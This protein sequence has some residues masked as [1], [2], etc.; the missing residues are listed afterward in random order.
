MKFKQDVQRG[1]EINE[2]AP[3][4][5]NSSEISQAS[6]LE[7]EKLDSFAAVFSNNGNQHSSHNP[8][9]DRN[10]YCYNMTHVT[11]YNLGQRLNC[12]DN[13]ESFSIGMVVALMFTVAAEILAHHLEHKFKDNII[14]LTMLNKIYKELMFMGL[15]GLFINMLESL[16]MFE[17]LFELSS[18]LATK[19]GFP[20]EH[21]IHETEH[22]RVERRV[23]IFDFVHVSLFFLSVFYVSMV[24]LWYYLMRRTWK[25]WK[26]YEE[27]SEDRAIS[28]YKHVRDKV[29]SSN[30]IALM[31]KYR[32][33]YNYTC[34]LDRLNYFTVRQRFIQVN[35]LM[36][37]SFRFDHYLKQCALHMFVHIIEIDSKTWIGCCVVFGINYLRNKLFDFSTTNSGVPLFVSLFSGGSLFISAIVYVSLRAAYSRYI[38]AHVDSFCKDKQT[39]HT[40]ALHAEVNPFS[41]QES[42]EISLLSQQESTSP[43]PP[44]K[45]ISNH[46]EQIRV[47][48]SGVHNDTNERRD[49]NRDVLY[50]DQDDLSVPL[51]DK[52]GIHLVSMNR[53]FFLRMPKLT[54]SLAQISL[55]IQSFYMS[56]YIL[57]F[58]YVI[59]IENS[60]GIRHVAP[61]YIIAF[62]F[63]IPSVFAVCVMFPL[64]MP[65]MVIMLSVDDHSNQ[66]EISQQLKR[67]DKRAIKQLDTHSENVETDGL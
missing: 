25:R 15:I 37:R 47:V 55:L 31:F 48:E 67:W 21:N 40:R 63:L 44:S 54:F 52:N 20:P 57:H 19:M 11:I 38:S 13:S 66:K 14:H 65:L 18:Y 45:I 26:R 51:D 7:T 27:G 10:E 64:I 41:Y 22:E 3:F 23:L 29:N 49:G 43:H 50:N 33:W 2:T 4:L 9:H 53:Y 17:N 16:N 24:A 60:F 35:D 28:Y 5:Y 39:S 12:K 8:V 61:R 36:G 1:R 46:L 6:S 32:L 42:D 59:V 30:K 56:L 58:I 62:G 34:A